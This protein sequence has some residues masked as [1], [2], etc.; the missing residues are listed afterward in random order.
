MA[1]CSL[2]D[3]YQILREAYSF[4]LQ[5]SRIYSKFNLRMVTESK[6][7]LER[8]GTARRFPSLSSVRPGQDWQLQFKI[9]YDHIL[10]NQPIAHL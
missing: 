4:H 2:A 8:G 7:H 1:E 6:F 10:Y 5:D 3:C 9:G